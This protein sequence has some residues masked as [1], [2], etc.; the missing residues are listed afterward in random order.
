MRSLAGFPPHLRRWGAGALGLAVIGC[1][2]FLLSQRPTGPETTRLQIEDGDSIARLFARA[3]LADSDLLALMEAERGAAF[4]LALVPGEEVR[5][6]RRE[7]GSLDRLLF[8]NGDR[9]ATAFISDEL[10]RFQV[11]SA[12][13][14]RDG[15]PA[16]A[17][18]VRSVARNHPATR[19]EGTP[20]KVAEDPP[21]SP[22]VV[23]RRSGNPELA[24]T[25]PPAENKDDPRPPESME[26]LNV[27]NGDSLYR[28][29]S[30]NGLLQTDL[31][32]L[33][34]SGGDGK[35]LK[36]LRPGQSIAFRREPD[37]RISRFHHEVDELTTVEFTRAGDAFNVPRGDP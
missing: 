36:R 35:K 8:G 11:A 33:V 32:H 24:S 28:I 30:R 27:R 6:I 23:D 16:G 34:A 15:E 13:A 12:P 10:N 26:R 9:E 31:Q 25:T 14:L 22:R 18:V 29:F 5:I 7:D 1:A 17:A 20:A 4:G 19:K 37:G 21:A 3:G 2:G